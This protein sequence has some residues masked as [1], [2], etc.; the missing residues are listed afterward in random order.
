MAPSGE[1]QV[2]STPIE[3]IRGTLHR[4]YDGGLGDSADGMRT[5]RPR[6]PTSAGGK[7][8][9]K[10]A[11]RHGFCS[12]LPVAAAAAAAAAAAVARQPMPQNHGSGLLAALLGL[13]PQELLQEHVQHLAKLRQKVASEYSLGLS[14]KALAT[15]DR[16]TQ[17]EVVSLPRRRHYQ[18]RLRWGNTE[19]ILVESWKAET[20]AMC[21]DCGSVQCEQCAGRVPF[22]GRCPP[23]RRY[24]VK[25]DRITW[26]CSACME[27]GESPWSLEA[28]VSPAPWPAAAAAPWQL[29]APATTVAAPWYRPPPSKP[30]PEPHPA[31]AEAAA[32][33]RTF[34]LAPPQP[35]P[36]MRQAAKQ[37]TASAAS[38]PLPPAFARELGGLG[39]AKVAIAQRTRLAGDEAFEDRICL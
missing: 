22:A 1:T 7:P 14:K 6:R 20:K 25:L 10:E 31:G 5:Q 4:R 23:G 17:C 2:W 26:C 34:W 39:S 24:A 16:L 8:Y 36:A 21:A 13:P 15:F 30:A 29:P 9:R 28:R 27:A 11:E 32:Q 3:A 38:P 37:G 35:Y 12:D 18:R 19:V 33:G